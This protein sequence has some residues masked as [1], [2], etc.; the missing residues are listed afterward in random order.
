MAIK[1]DTKSFDF[2][3]L[4]EY[5]HPQ[6]EEKTKY[7]YNFAAAFTEIEEYFIDSDN[8]PLRIVPCLSIPEG[9]VIAPSA[10]NRISKHR[11]TITFCERDGIGSVRLV[12]EQNNANCIPAE[13]LGIKTFFENL[14][15]YSNI[16]FTITITDGEGHAVNIVIEKNITPVKIA[17]ALREQQCKILEE[18]EEKSGITVLVEKYFA[19]EESKCNVSDK[20]REFAEEFIKV[21]SWSVKVKDNIFRICPVIHIPEGYKTEDSTTIEEVSKAQDIYLTKTDEEGNVMEKIKLVVNI[22]GTECI[23][24]NSDNIVGNPSFYFCNSMRFKVVFYGDDGQK[25][26]HEFRTVVTKNEMMKFLK[27]TFSANI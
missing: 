8:G 27:E 17:D 22:S 7:L 21:E 4:T 18:I 25:L 20:L 11:K 1:V 16:K 26:R 6:D 2:S 15:F 24:W 5:T 10:T 12:V 3:K 19:A 13:F 23:K 9:F 14:Y